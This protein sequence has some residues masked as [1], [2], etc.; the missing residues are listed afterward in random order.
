[1]SSRGSRPKKQFI[2]TLNDWK[3]SCFYKKLHKESRSDEG[4][5]S[6][7]TAVTTIAKQAKTIS[8]QVVQYFPHYT[9]HGEQH[10]KNVL[11]YMNWMAEE[12]IDDWG[13]VECGLAILASYVHDLGMVPTEAEKAFFDL[14]EDKPDLTKFSL[15]HRRRALAWFRFRAQ[16]PMWR[17]Y[18]AYPSQSECKKLALANFLRSSHASVTYT[19]GVARIEEHLNKIAN[20]TLSGENFFTVDGFSWLPGLVLLCLSHNED[21]KFI[22]KSL[23][24][25]SA[26]TNLIGANEYALSHHGQHRIHWPRLS[27]ALRMA[28]VI[29]MDDSRTPTILLHTITDPKSLIEWKK[30]CSIRKIELNESQTE[31]IYFVGECPDAETEHALREM[32]GYKDENQRVFAS[33]WINEELQN[34]R[35]AQ[36]RYGEA[37]SAL[38][39]PKVAYVDISSRAG[40]Y[41]YE[42]LVFKLKREAVMGLLMGEAL[43]GSRDICLREI[44]QNAL[45][46][47]HLRERYSSWKK[48][49]YHHPSVPDVSPIDGEEQ[50]VE[51]RWGKVEVLQGNEEKTKHYVEVRDTGVGMSLDTLKKY[52]TQVGQSFYTSRTFD[53]QRHEMLHNHRLLCTPISQFGIG[54]LAVFM[55]TDH[56]EIITRKS[57]KEKW[58]IDIHGPH[59][60]MKLTPLLSGG[61][62]RTGTWV[63]IWLKEGITFEK[64]EWASFVSRLRRYFYAAEKE[65]DRSDSKKID[66]AWAIARSVVWPLH[67]VVLFPP[68]GDYVPNSDG[69]PLEGV[70]EEMK[71]GIKLDGKFHSHYL[72]PKQELKPSLFRPWFGNEPKARSW[73]PLDWIDG[74]EDNPQDILRTPTGSQVRIWLLSREDTFQQATGTTGTADPAVS[75]QLAEELIEALP[76]HP[77][78]RSLVLINGLYIN[79]GHEL[80]PWLNIE[81]GH[82]SVV[83]LD[84]RGEAALKLRADRKDLVQDQSSVLEPAARVQDLWF[85][86]W[87]FD[88]DW[89]STAIWRDGSSKDEHTLDWAPSEVHRSKGWHWPQ[90]VSEAILGEASLRR[91]NT[92]TKPQQLHAGRR[93]QIRD[94]AFKFKHLKVAAFEKLPSEEPQRLSQ[95]YITAL[96]NLLDKEAKAG[97]LVDEYCLEAFLPSDDSWGYFIRSEKIRLAETGEKTHAKS[98]DNFASTLFFQEAFSQKSDRMPF[99]LIGPAPALSKEHLSLSGPMH[100]QS[101]DHLNA[102]PVLPFD[103]DL[104]APLT[105]VPLND[106]AKCGYW[107][108][109]RLWRMLFLLPFYLGCV[110]PSWSGKEHFIIGALAGAKSV[111]LYIPAEKFLY[112][113]WGDLFGTEWQTEGITI[114]WD[115]EKS[116]V[117]WLSGSVAKA[118]FQN[119]QGNLLIPTLQDG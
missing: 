98:W 11:S 104:V 23:S 29:D 94:T 93:S 28:D 42:E 76:V 44:V 15:E 14:D 9:N 56:V 85:E 117:S 35:A 39:L 36:G 105:G 86:A 75:A 78:R 70:P 19:D 92:T 49:D 4:L 107:K 6:F 8:E 116:Q 96:H 115:V 61:P 119:G 20:V 118:K 17:R 16:D 71:K 80:L 66:P 83:W 91:Q 114:Y 100:I 110:P 10:L 25:E 22:E 74:P 111:S 38:R 43:Y 13:A 62:E 57:D 55:L 3:D 31:L 46:A 81:P 12:S 34:V 77:K 32:T 87:K 103:H 41:H 26:Y 40:R 65:E 90:F 24:R 33:G 84:L 102:A 101:Y 47:V 21:V 7:L 106:L 72:L 37:R 82:G 79:N 68:D 50:R 54:F 88:Q 45:D 109:K 97:G 18:K 60:F 99:P 27:W 52:L 48:A 89:K 112:S 1:M 67:P 108:N 73:N 113:D 2:P 58:K 5:A 63:K 59:S 69:V 64:F 30:H 51:V 53:E 95:H